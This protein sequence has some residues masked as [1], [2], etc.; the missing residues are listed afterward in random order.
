MRG[1]LWHSANFFEDKNGEALFEINWNIQFKIKISTHIKDA[2]ST[3]GV[4]NI[5]VFKPA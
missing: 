5:C 3:G 4:V 2:L 1:P